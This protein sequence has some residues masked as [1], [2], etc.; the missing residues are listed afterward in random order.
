MKRLLL[1]LLAAIA[2]PTAVNAFPWDKD[3]IIKTDLDEEYIVKDSTVTIT[4][5]SKLNEIK[6]VQKNH[7]I[8]KCSNEGI[9]KSV[10]AVDLFSK[11][12]ALH[13]K[14]EDALIAADIST[15]MNIIKF[16][17]IFV[18]LNGKKTANTYFNIACINPELVNMDNPSYIREALD[19]SISELKAEI[20]DF[21]S[22]LAI[23][24]VKEAV[25]E[26]YNN[27]VDLTSIRHQ[28]TDVNF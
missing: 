27:F 14:A 16:R 2:L 23:E 26:K 21:N 24:S 20:P 22:G 1:P 5:W 19:F 9:K 13:V 18:D 11:R 3:I 25:C 4:P 28:A 15:P 8:D 10:C 12:V 17:P 7:P 6:A